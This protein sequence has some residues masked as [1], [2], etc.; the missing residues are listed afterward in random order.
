MAFLR[1]KT[2]LSTADHLARQHLL[3]SDALSLT[4]LFAITVALALITNTLYQ[5]YASHQSFLSR[6]WRARGESSLHHGDAQAAV[7]A[8]H[9]ALALTPGDPTIEMELAESLA[10][11]GRLQEAAAYF[12]TLAESQPGAGIIRLQLARL[13]VREGKAPQALEDYRRAINGDW[14]G[15]G[16]L[17]RREVRLE[18]IGFLLSTG[19]SQQ[20]RNELLVAASNAPVGD[21]TVL[22]NI[23]QLME[24]AQAPA[25]ALSLY[26][27]LLSHHPSLFAA[28]EGAGRIAF[29]AG[30]YA[31]AVPYLKRAVN[32]PEVAHLPDSQAEKLRDMLSQ[33]QHLL[34]LYPSLQLS[35]HDRDLRILTGRNIAHARLTSCLAAQA[36]KNQPAVS[37]NPPA[38]QPQESH[39]SLASLARRFVHHPAK[40]A[41]TPPIPSPGDKLQDLTARWNKLPA[42]ITLSSLANQ[43]ELAS[44]QIQLIYD[45]EIVTAEVC[46]PPTDEDDALL[47]KIAQ[48][49]NAVDEQ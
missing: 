37:A 25:D 10:A 47:L 26:K 32:A 20:A 1:Q 12:N 41:S 6:R 27:S 48:A 31:E 45:T 13:A 22:L 18:M 46:G 39:N 30:H 28:L 33:S 14:E 7:Y 40:A 5:S 43:P 8:L 36:A 49:P 44:T 15:N 9:S 21:A 23:A 17:R 16:A 29:E 19:R 4:I 34:L 42:K 24:K 3:I 2:T 35:L 38:I 11:A